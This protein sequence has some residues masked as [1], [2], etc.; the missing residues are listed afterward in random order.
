MRAQA[1]R[2]CIC[3]DDPIAEN[4][5]YCFACNPF[6]CFYKVIIWISLVLVGVSVAAGISYLVFFV[7]TNAFSLLFAD[8]VCDHW[9]WG[10]CSSHVRMNAGKS[11]AE[12]QVSAGFI[13]SGLVILFAIFMTLAISNVY[14]FATFISAYSLWIYFWIFTSLFAGKQL[15][16]TYFSNC[17]DY[18]KYG[19]ILTNLFPD[20]SSFSFCQKIRNIA[21]NKGA[22]E[23]QTLPGDWDTCNSC[24]NK[25]YWSIF[26]PVALLPLIVFAIVL[27][28]KRY[29]R[30]YKY[31]LQQTQLNCD[32]E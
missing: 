1:F 16:T 7:G 6:G 23:D 27:L 10:W 24:M 2:N 4:C 30:K 3:G 32:E 19:V 18:N 26:V 22:I 20:Q 11:L 29:N 5:N 21:P 28:V 17:Q 9:I 31:L 25:G 12:L 13:V 14:P 8:T 15:A